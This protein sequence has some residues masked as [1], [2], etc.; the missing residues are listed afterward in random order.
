M[1]NDDD[2]S[3]YLGLAQLKTEGEPIPYDP[4]YVVERDRSAPDP[5]Y[6]RLG[7]GR[8]FYANRGIIGLD[9]DGNA[10]GGYDGGF[11]PDVGDFTVDERREIAE[12]MIARWRKFGGIDG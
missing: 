12:M 4:A 10:F 1:A 11:G 5:D 3:R 9:S 8:A 7:S 6:V 2:R